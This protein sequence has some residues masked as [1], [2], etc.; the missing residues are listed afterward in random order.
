[1]LQLR[2]LQFLLPLSTLL[3]PPDPYP[4]PTLPPPSDPYPD[5]TLPPLLT[6]NQTLP[7]P[8]LRHGR[9]SPQPR[10]SLPLALLTL[11]PHP[12]PNLT[13]KP[14]PSPYLTRTLPCFRLW[15]GSW[16]GQWGRRRCCALP[17]RLCRG[18][19][20]SFPLLIHVHVSSPLLCAR[21]L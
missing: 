20:G 17:I 6:L 12:N 7:C 18:S 8:L 2:V 9:P 14:L 10:P 1:M 5:P 3:L 13:S 4:D 15:R 19:R 16:W 11:C 21:H